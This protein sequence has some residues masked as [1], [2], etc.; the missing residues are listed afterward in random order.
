MERRS[1]ILLS[2]AFLLMVA[3]C[4]HGPVRY[5]TLGYHKYATVEMTSAAPLL[6]KP[7]VAPIGLA[8]DVL[9]TAVDTPVN[10]LWSIP[11]TFTHGGPDCNGIQTKDGPF[12]TAF[13]TLFVPFWYPFQIVAVTVWPKEMYVEVFGRETGVYRD[14]ELAVPEKKRD[15]PKP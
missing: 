1:F 12:F 10:I 7:I 2:L 8:T 13:Q 4:A 11:L 9:I 14:P 15:I 3:G 5:K 6:A